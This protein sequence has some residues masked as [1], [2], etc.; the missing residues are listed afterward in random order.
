MRTS[1]SWSLKVTNDLLQVTH[2]NIPIGAI[3]GIECVRGGHVHSVDGWSLPIHNKRYSKYIK[4]H[5]KMTKEIIK[6]QEM[7]ST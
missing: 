6:E 2:D 3:D 4:Q 7:G 5:L 1:T